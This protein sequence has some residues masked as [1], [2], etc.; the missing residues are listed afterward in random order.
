MDY[1]AQYQIKSGIH[2]PTDISPVGLRRRSC[3]WAWRSTTSASRST[4]STGDAD[5]RGVRAVLDLRRTATCTRASSPASASNST[6]TPPPRS[7]TS[8]PTCRTTASWTAPSMTGEAARPPRH[9]GRRGGAGNPPSA[10]P[11]RADRS[12]R[13]GGRDHRRRMRPSTASR[14]AGSSKT[15]SWSCPTPSASTRRQPSGQF[16]VCSETRRSAVGVATTFQAVPPLPVGVRAGVQLL[17]P[18]GVGGAEVEGQGLSQV[19]PQ[20]L[21]GGQS[22]REGRR[23]HR[24]RGGPGSGT[25]GCRDWPPPGARRPWARTRTAC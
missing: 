24:D 15:A 14:H 22:T 16:R 5:Q 25:A 21:I 10:P 3:T 9:H 8:R 18:R 6:R 11:S 19:A 17:V 2:G 7:R 23:S 12:S 13:C 4:C 20:E 1:A